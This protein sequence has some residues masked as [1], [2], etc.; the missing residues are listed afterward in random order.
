MKHCVHP[1]HFFFHDV[2]TTDIYTL[3]LHAALPIY[4]SSS[5][6]FRR[7]SFVRLSPISDC[8]RLRSEEHTAEL[9]SHSDLVC[10]LLL[11]KKKRE[12]DTRPGV[13]MQYGRVS[14]ARCGADL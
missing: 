2:S 1:Y 7:A 6:A 9:Q 13:T 5:A 3:F 12:G 4:R 10:R 14:A 11:E 8:R